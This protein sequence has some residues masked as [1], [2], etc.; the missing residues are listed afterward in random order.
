ML[1]ALPHGGDQKWLYLALAAAG[2]AALYYASQGSAAAADGSSDDGSDSS[3]TGAA[4]DFLS[5]NTS[6]VSTFLQG[7]GYYVGI[8]PKG[9]RDNNPGNLRYVASIPWQGLVGN[10]GTGY[11]VFDTAEN[12]V[13]AMGHQLR[14]YASRG[15]NSV[16]QIISTYA[17][18]VENN[19]S[20]YIADVAGDL[21]VEPGDFIDVN[22]I[23]P[24]LVAAM[25]KHE[26][27]IQ[28]F[29]DEE[30]QAWVYE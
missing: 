3:A 5:E 27:G 29:S 30:L 26:Q 8:P 23:L 10:D 22:G 7:L 18:S 4:A 13:R 12:G 28:P 19:T 9:L 6:R 24:Q 15:L 1:G 16:A 25:I 20:A 17:P 11:C 21:G 14:T 2:A